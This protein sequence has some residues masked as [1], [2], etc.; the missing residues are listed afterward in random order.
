M[1]RLL[2]EKLKGV[3]IYSQHPGVVKT[4]IT[5]NGGWFFKSIFSVLGKSPKNGARTLVYLMESWN[6]D[7]SNGGY[8]ARSKFSKTSKESYDMEVADELMKR[9]LDYLGAYLDED[10]V[11]S[12]KPNSSKN[13]IQ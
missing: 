7:L 9:C 6:K 10:G 13:I 11:L 4:E 1:C 12:P 2:S 5:R 8:Y 3:G